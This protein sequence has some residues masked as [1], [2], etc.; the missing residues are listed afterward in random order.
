[1]EH[2]NKKKDIWLGVTGYFTRRRE[3]LTDKGLLR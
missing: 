1:M 2:R 3:I